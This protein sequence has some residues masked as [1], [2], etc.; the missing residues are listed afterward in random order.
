MGHISKSEKHLRPNTRSLK[1][2]QN[3]KQKEIQ[4]IKVFQQEHEP[5]KLMIKKDQTATKSPHDKS[6][7]HPSTINY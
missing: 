5:F 3:E 2:V 4:K 1:I 6:G 7:R